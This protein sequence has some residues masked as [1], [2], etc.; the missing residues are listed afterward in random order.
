[1]VDGRGALDDFACTP[2]WEV[3]M[4]VLHWVPVKAAVLTMSMVCVCVHVCVRVVYVGVGASVRAACECGS[5]ARV[6]VRGL[7]A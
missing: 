1:M 5:G 7:G 2:S 4:A 3:L 6:S